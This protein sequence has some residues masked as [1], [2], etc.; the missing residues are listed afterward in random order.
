MTKKE[1]R[2]QLL[3]D[4]LNFINEG[5]MIVTERT[6]KQRKPKLSVTGKQSRY[7]TTSAPSG[8]PSMMWDSIPMTDK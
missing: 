7:F 2:R 3:I 5:G 8:R 6:P 1:L 4:T